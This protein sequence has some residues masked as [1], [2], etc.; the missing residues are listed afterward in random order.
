MQNTELPQFDRD[1]PPQLGK[2]VI[3]A[4]V[5]KPGTIDFSLKHLETLFVYSMLPTL[6]Y[7]YLQSIPLFG[8]SKEHIAFGASTATS[9]FLKL[10][11]THLLKAIVHAYNVQC[12]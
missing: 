8:L 10:V 3:E 7:R 2:G 9:C 11:R 1:S 4:Q 12:L 5:T 6:I